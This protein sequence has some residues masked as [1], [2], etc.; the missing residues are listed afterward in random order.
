MKTNIFSAFIA[1]ILCTPSFLAQVH[2]QPSPVQV[3]LPNGWSLS[4]AGT[5]MPLGDLPLNMVFSASHK[6]LAVTNNGQSD[7][8]LQL[9]DPQDMKQLDSVKMKA[10]WLGL[11]FSSDEKSL[12]VSGGNTNTIIRFDVSHQKLMPQD[13]FVLGKPWPELISPAGL[14]L[15]ESRNLLYVVTKESNSLYFIDRTTKQIIA[16]Y[17]LGGEGYTCLLSPDK[18]IIYSSCWGCACIKV[19]DLEKKVW[20]KDIPTGD[21]PNDMCMTRKGNFLFV[22]NS[23]DNSVSVIDLHTTRVVETLNAALY[24]ASP[25]GS[26]TNS[27]ALSEDE[28]TLYV[29]NADNNCL[30]LFDVS[31][32]GFSRSKG[33]IPTGWYPTCVRVSGK[34]IYVANGK[35]FTSLPN[36][37]GPNPTRKEEEVVYQHGSQKIT[38]KEQYIGGLFQGT[39]SKIPVPDANLLGT[40]SFQVYRNTPFHKQ[41]MLSAEGETG[42]PIPRK[43]GEQSPIKHVFYIIKENRT[44]DQILGD[45]KQGNGDTSLVLFGQKS[46]P[47]Q[48]ALVNEFVLYDNFYVDGE[49]SADGHNWSTGA[50]ATDYLEKTWPTYYGGRGGEYE[51]EGH[52]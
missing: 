45:V 13:T 10:S 35:G 39:L 5:S 38:G 19:F 9:L 36:P 21:H 15:D 25:S 32:P 26:T 18:K 27:V 44:Y 31:K 33:F 47:N 1:L 46:T 51:S 49:V 41:N 42:N 16:K 22:A 37:L 34:D 52:T 29:A 43:L 2:N 17:I 14:C 48:H 50:Y 8:V 40:Y 20:K 6:L 11:C 3:R 24:P 30:A 4:P 28:Q 7:Q 12:Y 23:N